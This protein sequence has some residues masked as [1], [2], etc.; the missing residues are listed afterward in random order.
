MKISF[1]NLIISLIYILLTIIVSFFLSNYVLPYLSFDTNTSFLRFK[2][3][4]VHINFWLISFYIH[5]FSAF[6]ALACGL[7]QFSTNIL[8]EY[9]KVHSIVGKIYAWDILIINFPTGMVLALTAIG[10]W[11]SKLGFVVLDCLWFW[12][13]Y[14]AVKLIK[15]KKVAPHK[16]FMIRSYSLTLSAI[17]LRTI[18]FT[19]AYFFHWNP[20]LVYTISAWMGWI[21]NLI[22][23]EWII[24][25]ELNS[26]K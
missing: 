7:F 24:Q 11:I 13:T 21:P 9:K 19:C 25:K 15:Q 10:P 17:T 8:R 23:A 22:I 18:N 16:H 6:I 12:F 14:K 5:V 2:Q 20:I 4:Y 1:P 3:Q 26:L